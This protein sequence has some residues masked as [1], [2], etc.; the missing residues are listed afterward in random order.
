MVKMAKEML[1][2]KAIVGFI[3]PQKLSDFSTQLKK[4]KVGGKFL[5]LGGGD[6][7][8]PL[9]L[10]VSLIPQST[11]HALIIAFFSVIGLFA[12][13]LIFISQKTRAPMPALPPIALFSI[14]GYLLTK[15]L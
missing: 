13:F 12:G 8:F 5:I 15:V 1:Q 2:H 9:I 10:A 6:I 14:L 7:V 11:L 3:I 4:V